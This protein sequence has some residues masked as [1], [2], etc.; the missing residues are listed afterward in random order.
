MPDPTDPPQGAYPLTTNSLSALATYTTHPSSGLALKSTT[1]LPASSIFSPITTSTPAPIKLYSTVQVSR[2]A[3]IEL[4]SALLYL[5]HSCSPS[6]EIDTEKMEVRVVKDRDLNEGDELSFFYPS[7]EWAFDRP[8]E[9]LCGAAQRGG[10]CLGMVRGAKYLSRE[11]LERG[12]WFVNKHILGMV[13]ERD[14]EGP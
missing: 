1:S 6:L 13:R 5:N 8:F 2:S 9:C 12:G 11:E 14:A 4:N 10:T 7:T 3:H